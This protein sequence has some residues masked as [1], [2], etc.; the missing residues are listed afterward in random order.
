M[1]IN[2]RKE[3][4]AGESDKLVTEAFIQNIQDH[5]VLDYCNVPPYAGHSLPQT[6]I[7]NAEIKRDPPRLAA[8]LRTAMKPG[9]VAQ[10]WLSQYLA[11]HPPPAVTYTPKRWS[12]PGLPP[13]PAAGQYRSEADM[14]VPAPW[15]GNLLAA[16]RVRFTP[17]NNKATI[18][19]K[20]AALKQNTGS[21]RRYLDEFEKL[22]QQLPELQT[23]DQRK[24]ALWKGAKEQIRNTLTGIL[25]WTDDVSYTVFKQ[26]LLDVDEQQWQLRI[27]SRATGTPNARNGSVNKSNKSSNKS[28]GTGA[29]NNNKVPTN[30]PDK[31][32]S[33]C[34]KTGHARSDC[35]SLNRKW[36]HG[37][38][39]PNDD[40]QSDAKRAK[41]NGNGD[42][43]GRNEKGSRYQQR[44]HPG[45]VNKSEYRNSGNGNKSGGNSANA[46]ESDITSDDDDEETTN[47][48]NNIEELV[49]GKVTHDDRPAPANE[50]SYDEIMRQV[51]EAIS[52]VELD[53][54]ALEEE[55]AATTYK[56]AV[57]V[58]TARNM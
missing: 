34:R 4:F 27:S 16:L 29:G 25:N 19:A 28:T 13:N 43:S 39:R 57:E 48:I 32:C 42:R 22:Q 40:T 53:H 18:T 9:S 15:L 1:H 30:N 50:D 51:E 44:T 23:E 31:Y 24:F 12:N 56:D 21:F 8:L 5:L 55:D 46:V 33:H 26:R 36:S 6:A 49:T 2:L 37:I 45:N 38:K 11:E 35:W 7:S 20:L 14:P 41:G 54:K 52:S 3:K 10:T 58:Q 17:P 47:C